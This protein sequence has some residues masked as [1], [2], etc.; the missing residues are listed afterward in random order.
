MLC[1]I[2]SFDI[3][4]FLRTAKKRYFVNIKVL[5]SFCVRYSV[6]VT[7]FVLTTCMY[8]FCLQFL[9]WSVCSSVHVVVD[10]FNRL[11]L[12]YGAV[13][14]F[15][16]DISCPVMSGGPKY[17]RCRNVLLYYYSSFSQDL[18]FPNET[19]T[20]M[21]SKSNRFLFLGTWDCA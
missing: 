14:E 21:D 9:Y 5:C 16:T 17:V 19:N 11:N 8:L 15:C 2:R 13:S 6:K 10:F 3:V 18:N 20:G 4:L 1:I 12:I 7:L